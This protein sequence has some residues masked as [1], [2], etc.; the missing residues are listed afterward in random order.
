[1]EGSD[2]AFASHPMCPYHTPTRDWELWQEAAERVADRHF[3]HCTP[4]FTEWFVEMAPQDAL[5]SLALMVTL[6]VSGS[7][8][9]KAQARRHATR[10]QD[11]FSA[12]VVNADDVSPW[13]L[14]RRIFDE[15]CKEYA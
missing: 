3:H 14:E 15:V 13:P 12:F 9:E 10:I 4:E 2:A 7:G 11:D 6:M 8:E 5:P 1:M